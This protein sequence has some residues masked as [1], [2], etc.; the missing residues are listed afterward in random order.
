MQAIF[1]SLDFWQWIVQVLIVFFF[2]GGVVGTVVGVGL[3]FRSAQ[4]L[5]AFSTLNRWT[6]LRKAARPLEIPRDTTPVVQKNRYLLGLACMICGAIVSYVLLFRYDAPVIIL[7]L[8]LN[9]LPEAYVAWLLDATRWTLL[10]GNLAAIVVGSLL[11]F[12]PAVLAGIETRGNRW[13]SE[14]K[15]LK[16]G[17]AVHSPL[18]K[19]VA[20]FPR[21]AGVIITIGSLI[22][23]GNFGL[24]LLSIR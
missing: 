5:K 22:L 18:D 16:I 13:Y 23:V 15:F 3:I 14:R 24:L 1:N 9:A 21:P 17:D 20:A 10:I 2:I 6:S 4:A 19:L 12:F 11:A 8:R 7:G